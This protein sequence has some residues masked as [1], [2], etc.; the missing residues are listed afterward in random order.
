MLLVC[1]LF[2]AMHLLKK[3]ISLA[4]EASWQCVF[5]HSTFNKVIFGQETV[6]LLEYWNIHY[7]HLIWLLVIHVSKTKTLPESISF[8]IIWM[9]QWYWKGFSENDINIVSRHNI[10]IGVYVYT[11][12]ASIL[13]MTIHMEGLVP[14]YRVILVICLTLYIIMRNFVIWIGHITLFG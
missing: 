10:D 13:K 5:S 2:V 4:R 1:G 12:K 8:W 7:T 6:P 3:T 11:Q 14:T 9:C